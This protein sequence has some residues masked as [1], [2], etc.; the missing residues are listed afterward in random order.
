MAANYAQGF[1]ITGKEPIDMRLIKT[2]AEMATTKLRMPDTYF[3]ICSDD[4]QLYLYDRRNTLDPELGYYR[5]LKS[6]EGPGSIEWGTFDSNAEE[7]TD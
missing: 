6:G 4:G 5:L 2:K 3:C 1:N 7:V